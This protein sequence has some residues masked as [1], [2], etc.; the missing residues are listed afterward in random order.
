MYPVPVEISILAAF[1][2]GGLPGEPPLLEELGINLPLIQRKTVTVLNPMQTVDSR[3]M[4]DADLWGPILFFIAFGAF[5]LLSGKAH[6]SYIYGL[7]M[8]GWL[9]IYCLLNMMSEAGL[10]L[11]RTASVLGYCLLPMVLLSSL[12]ILLRL[13]GLFGYGLG[14]ASVA[15]CTFASSGIFVSVLGMRNQRFLIAYPVALFY[16]CFALITIF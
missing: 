3:I 12:S 16:A 9:S 6:F 14:I 10:D 8:L 2:T 4:D 11:Y 7:A 1:G 15:W 5:L 13:K